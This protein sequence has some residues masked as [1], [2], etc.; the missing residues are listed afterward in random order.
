MWAKT[1]G[2]SALGQV[3]KAR[4]GAN[5]L[6]DARLVTVYG[7][8]QGLVRSVPVGA[9]TEDRGEFDAEQRVL[10]LWAVAMLAL[11]VT[12]AV[13]FALGYVVLFFIEVRRG[14]KACSEPTACAWT[15]E[16][17]H[18]A[19]R[20]TVA[21]QGRVTHTSLQRAVVPRLER[22]WPPKQ[23]GRAEVACLGSHPVERCT[24]SR[25]RGRPRSISTSSRHEGDT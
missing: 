2:F 14:A 20:I 19:C 16:G 21:M 11:V 4:S 12:I 13:I 10:W 25:R 18:K 3:L 6:F 8:P 9:I 24:V 5:A 22:H 15:C 7:K 17:H 23:A 1:L